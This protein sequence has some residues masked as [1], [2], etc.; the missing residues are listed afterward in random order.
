MAQKWY[1]NSFTSVIGPVNKISKS[2][3]CTIPNDVVAFLGLEMGN[4]REWETIRHE[5][6]RY[7]RIRKLQ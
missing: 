3:R 5:G 4:V 7:A 1:H 2:L 6:K